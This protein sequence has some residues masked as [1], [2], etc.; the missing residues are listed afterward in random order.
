MR[1]FLFSLSAVLVG[2][3]PG[4][5][6]AD[7]VYTVTSVS[8]DFTQTCQDPEGIENF[9]NDQFPEAVDPGEGGETSD[10]TSVTTTVASLQF[11]TAGDEAMMVQGNAVTFG[12]WNSEAKVW[13]FVVDNSYNQVQDVAEGDF[14]SYVWTYDVTDVTTYAVDFKAGTATY[15]QVDAADDME[16]ETDEWTADEIMSSSMANGWWYGMEGEGVND[17]TLDDCATDTC[18]IQYITNCETTGSLTVAE[19]AA[20]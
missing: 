17:P 6:V 20:E 1:T 4:G 2:C 3:G 5:G 16:E 18:V 10:V 14:Y 19:A 13:E 12:T 7:A 15:T 9:N 8:S 11:R